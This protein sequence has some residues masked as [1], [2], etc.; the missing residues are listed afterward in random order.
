M[1]GKACF[2][3]ATSEFRV[4]RPGWL[5]HVEN[6]DPLQT[7]IFFEVGVDDEVMS[8]CIKGVDTGHN[9]DGMEVDDSMNTIGGAAD[10]DAGRCDVTVEAGRGGRLSRCISFLATAQ[11]IKRRPTCLG[12]ARAQSCYVVVL[13]SAM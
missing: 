7:Y 8:M 12:A 11:M 9:E 4:A 10:D 3:N 1:A 13:D 2:G 6:E 5:A